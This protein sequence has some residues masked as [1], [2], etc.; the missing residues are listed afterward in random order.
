[1]KWHARVRHDRF[2]QTF[3]AIHNAQAVIATTKP[4]RRDGLV[5]LC[6]GRSVSAKEKLYILHVFQGGSGLHDG[7]DFCLRL[8]IQSRPNVLLTVFPAQGL[9]V[10][11][12]KSYY[13]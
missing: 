4:Q 5:A 8:A 11:V 3:I 6:E 2:I 10:D 12:K 9:T 13:E 7:L 1:M